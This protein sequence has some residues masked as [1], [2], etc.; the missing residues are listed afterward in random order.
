MMCLRFE[1]DCFSTLLIQWVLAAFFSLPNS[2]DLSAMQRTFLLSC[3]ELPYFSPFSCMDP[4]QGTAER[5]HCLWAWEG[6]F[7]CLQKYLKYFMAP[8]GHFQYQCL[9][10]KRKPCVGC[11][12]DPDESRSCSWTL[13]LLTIHAAPLSPVTKHGSWEGSLRRD[14][15]PFALPSPRWPPSPDLHPPVWYIQWYVQPPP[16]SRCA[17]P[18]AHNPSS[19]AHKS[20]SLQTPSPN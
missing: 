13:S 19:V 15:C 5:T 12:K 2:K 8:L 9:A 1:H 18:S 6:Q 20:L 7:P 10:Q 14:N 11:K 3:Y 16:S 17:P 4:D